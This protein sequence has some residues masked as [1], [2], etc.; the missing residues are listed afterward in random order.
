MVNALW[1][2]RWARAAVVA[3]AI[4]SWPGCA[5]DPDAGDAGSGIRA[6]KFDFV[7]KDM[8][9][10]DVKLA[11]FKGK[12]VLLNFWATWCAP[13]KAEI[14]WFIEFADKYKD[15]GLVIVGVSVDDSAED[16]KAFAQE[17]KINY[18]MLVGLGHDSLMEE[19]EATFAVPVSWFI[20]ADG[21]VST[22]APGIHPKDW[23]EAQIKALF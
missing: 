23:F 11:D 8:N 18:P 3:A 21:T 15:K 17:Y 9:G 12:A 5:M 16:I 6:A 1:T 10:A 4:A 14:P 20:R 7:L 19:Y 13:C 2:S 22:R